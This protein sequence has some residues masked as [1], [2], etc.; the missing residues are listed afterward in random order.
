MDGKGVTKNYNIAT[1]W[2]TKAANQGNENAKEGLRIIR[3]QL[4]N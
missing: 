3:T 1:E 4:I 2:L